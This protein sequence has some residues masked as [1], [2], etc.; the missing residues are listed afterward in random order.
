MEVDKKRRAFGVFLHW[1]LALLSLCIERRR[2]LAT[3]R[4]LG[5][6]R[7]AIANT[8][9][10]EGALITTLA[11]VIGTILSVALGWLLIYIINKQ[12][13]GWTLAFQIPWMEMFLS[14]LAILVVASLTSWRIGW[15]AARLP[16]DREE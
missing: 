9:A 1:T 7:R 14:S 10:L 12:S 8:L 15:W 6:D 2:E 4:E 16:A 11:N 13:F 3:L 5:M